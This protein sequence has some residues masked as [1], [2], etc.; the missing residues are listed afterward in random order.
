MLAGKR[1]APHL[2][3]VI[4][5]WLCGLYDNDRSVARAA[6]DSLTAAFTTAEKRKALWKIYKDALVDH[7]QDAILV[8]TSKTLSD[9]RTTTADDAEA[10]FVRV[11]G[12]AM[13]MFSQLVK[14]DAVN[15]SPGAEPE[16]KEKVQRLLGDKKL[17]EY[18]YCQDPYLRRGICHL[19][20]DCVD[21]FVDDLDWTTISTCFVS[22]GLHG[23]QQG[24]S[25]QFSEALLVLTRAHSQIWTTDYSSKTPALKRLVQY[26]RKGSQRGPEDVWNNTAMLLKQIPLSVFRQ[27]DFEHKEAST[28]MEAFRA[29]V[30]HPDEPRPNLPVAWTAYVDLCFWF[31]DHTTDPTSRESILT[32]HLLPIVDQ[33]VR[34][35][36][37][38]VSWTLPSSAALQV[39]GN[40]FVGM[41]QRDC[42][43]LLDDT[44][45]Q[46]YQD[47]IDWMKLSLP[48][49][50]K[51]F[52]KSQDGVTARA[53]RLFKLK[54]GMLARGGLDH[55]AQ[56]HIDAM[57]QRRD[58]RLIVA[59]IDTLKTRKG[60]PYGA[61][62]VLEIVV[63]QPGFGGLQQP[64]L[65][66]F[67][68]QDL[69]PMLLSVSAERL[70]SVLL[71][72]GQPIDPVVPILLQN[73]ASNAHA[74]DALLRLLKGMGREQLAGL[75]G[76][77]AFV[78]HATSS[79]IEEAQTRQLVQVVL[80][81]ANLKSSRLHKR[82][83]EQL[84][85]LLSA[86]S[87]PSTQQSVMHLF[88]DILSDSSSA[89]VLTSDDFGSALIATLVQLSDSHDQ[90]TADQ[91][92]ALLTK[93][94]QVNVDGTLTTASAAT[95]VREQLAGVG[96][97]LSIFAVVDLAR[98]T[99]QN[100]TGGD[101]QTISALLPTR[102]QWSQALAPHMLHARPSSLAI[103]STLK[104]AIYAIEPGNEDGPQPLTRDAEDLSLAFRITLYVT[105]MLS[106]TDLFHL[107]TLDRRQSVYHYYPI[108]LQ[109]VNEK[110]TL[111]TASEMWLQSSD[112]IIDE[113]ADL[114]G[115]GHA[116]V[117]TWL[118]EKGDGAVANSLED[119]WMASKAHEIQGA[120][121]YAYC[122]GLTFTDIASRINN[123]RGPA[124]LLTRFAND[125]QDV[126]RSA[127][128]MRSASL[129]SIFRDY[130]TTSPQGRRLLNELIAD[131]TDLD[132]L[133]PSP[134]ASRPLVLLNILLDGHSSVLDTIPSQRLV[135]L[136]QTLI[137]LL[138]KASEEWPLISEMLSLLSS[139]LP[140]IS[141]IYGEHWE[142]VTQILVRLWEQG[143]DLGNNLPVLHSSLRLYGHLKSLAI[144]E[145]ANEDLV[146][147]WNA[148]RSSLDTGLLQCLDLFGNPSR[149]LNQPRRITAELL[150]RQ[151]SGVSLSHGREI[152]HLLSS[153]EEAVQNAAYELL[154]QAIPARQ[155]QLSL[156]L[157]LDKKIA[158]LPA[159]L[160][161]LLDDR[162]GQTVPGDLVGPTSSKRYLLAWHLVFDHF[163][164]ASY[165][166]R[167]VYTLDIKESK[168][169]PGLL[170]YVCDVCR[171]TSGRPVD[172]SK[173]D[174]KRFELEGAESGEKEE[175]WL[176]VHLY[177]NCLLYLPSLT[178]AWFI[179]QKN[180][181]KSPLESWT[182]KYF[183]PALVSASLATVTDWIS[184]QSQEV[185]DAPIAV[186]SSPKGS[187]LVASIAIDP[188]SPPIS[189]AIS[190]PSA[191]P[192]DSPSVSSRTRVGV[193]E[194][195]W[196]SWLR[197]FQI[198]IF[199]TGSIIEGLVA[200]RRNVQGA[201]KGQS[202]CAICYS[203][204]GTDMQTPNK[205][206][207]TCRNTFHGSCLFRWFKS[208]N[209]SSCPLCR[210]NFN[211]A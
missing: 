23:S 165:Q 2:S 24:S 129:V 176:I 7:A 188:E 22:K 20:I 144:S 81:N 94:K 25:R 113:A 198:I 190:L 160:L 74:M 128:L 139:V 72:T 51:D 189:L 105:K 47:L 80:Q 206:C 143:D 1:M 87:A 137:R 116:L 155:E 154:H 17:W 39:S 98:G 148:A 158:H 140:N 149:G 125:L 147:A 10:K 161:S 200:F 16:F 186:K 58:E 34:N 61:A 97:P 59:A 70:I 175:Q 164:R 3:K 92:S 197:T 101:L 141:D 38:Q 77:E 123:T 209:S 15:L 120:S 29:G 194:K 130:L 30:T 8:Q 76:L 136:M 75:V 18:A 201:L 102:D 103:T 11:V 106:T 21:M 168:V 178:R 142:T 195:N 4:G 114:L 42:G 108:A 119:V 153:T 170:D 203:I 32:A 89:A 37:N 65:R 184:T 5:P 193:S 28:V 210:N 162:P 49:S 127:E 133:T 138:S 68:A 19:A 204:I 67:C 121:P 71:R 96:T 169:L 35:D 9:E 79:N 151:L 196:Q 40:I 85:D 126:R 50:S 6:Q 44:W 110:L 90:E 43:N 181:V 177:Y 132:N 211:Y 33:Y 182:Q 192:L 135:F 66:Q 159:E 163:T 91:A 13:Y 63:S 12:T 134:S 53:E 84:M 31:M 36:P 166:L 117:Q 131:A 115:E 174:I 26:L 107:T 185:D 99:L 104:G 41:L 172:A 27:G 122:L 112:E 124:H 179:E 152:Y 55:S 173:V 88:D 78:V 191:Y 57:L 208:S 156:D 64:S 95:I 205:R 187:E 199:S 167:E 14:S 83:L 52:A 73:A 45:S 111:E 150:R 146:D 109:L 82:L 180:R 202:E 118:Q 56:A 145:D 62:A 207:G 54:A 69:S 183:S 48:E 60:K 86:S 46:L 93:L 171:I 100:V 157:A